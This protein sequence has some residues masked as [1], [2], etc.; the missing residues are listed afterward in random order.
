MANP[1]RGYAGPQT[2]HLPAG[3]CHTSD[4]LHSGCSLRH[5]GAGAP[6]GCHLALQYRDHPGTPG[7]CSA[8]SC[9]GSPGWWSLWDGT[10][11]SV[12][13][14][15]GR[16]ESRMLQAACLPQQEHACSQMYGPE[17]LLYPTGRLLKPSS[18]QCFPQCE[19]TGS[20]CPDEG[21]YFCPSV[22]S[23]FP[24][25]CLTAPSLWHRCYCICTN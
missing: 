4:W 2:R 5:E 24:L 18:A 23:R 12:A 7:R 20:A 10:G 13:S 8:Q 9:P 22:L 16:L 14:G 19:A 11:E 25:P 15:L 3:T 21:G 6:C 1:G 17:P